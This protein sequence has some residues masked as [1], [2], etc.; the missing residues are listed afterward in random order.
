MKSKLSAALAVAAAIM[1]APAA[2]RADQ[3]VETHPVFPASF[4]FSADQT[5]FFQISP[6]SQFDTSR[7]TL[8]SV[9]ADL[10][11]TPPATPPATWTPA[12]GAS[13]LD[14]FIDLGL[15]AFSKT[16]GPGPLQTPLSL[17]NEVCGTGCF[18]SSVVE[19]N[20]NIP[21]VGLG[22]QN[23]SMT[24]SG[25]LNTGG[26]NL[27]FTYTFTPAAPVPAPIAG[28]GLPGLVLASGG[29]L[30]WWRRRKKVA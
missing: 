5:I 7:G 9:S 3:I 15:T 24:G 20:G 17:F 11:F 22:A 10:N 19:G 27:E 1:L 2:G 13:S 28:A 26:I 25:T 12:D 18:L 6:Y 14:F 8:T 16:V 4:T 30:G 29:L 23:M 21:I